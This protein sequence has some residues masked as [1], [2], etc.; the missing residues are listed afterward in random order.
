MDVRHRETS[1]AQL[2][3]HL[4]SE[5]SPVRFLVGAQAW[6]AIWSLIEACS[7]GS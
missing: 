2:V 4:Q 7:R 3:E 6:V 5:R 1:V